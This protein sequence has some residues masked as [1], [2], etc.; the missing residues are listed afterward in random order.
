MQIELSKIKSSPQAIRTT[1]SEEKMDELAQS[2]KQHGLLQ[3]VKVR[4]AGDKYE[5]V[6]GHRRVEACRR[7]GLGVIEAVVKDVG[8][9]TAL[10]QGLIENI[11]RE[12]LEPLDKALGLKVLQDET[13]WSLREMEQ[14]LG[15]S[16]G[17]VRKLL[18]LLEEPKEIQQML[19]QPPAGVSRGHTSGTITAK[20]VEQVRA[21]KLP[22]EQHIA[23]LKKAAEEGLTASQARVEARILKTYGTEE[24]Q[25]AR[26]ERHAQQDAKD[27]EQMW[28]TYQAGEG[29]KNL[30][31][32]IKTTR[33]SFAHSWLI[34]E[35]GAIGPE[36][37]PYLEKRL[38]VLGEYLV[39]L[40]DDLDERRKEAIDE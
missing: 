24:E 19:T 8:P 18:A 22:Q 26:V 23:I 2:I 9:N 35:R 14:H 4:P 25:V 16:F 27:D 10:I 31:R 20:H 39:G 32:T 30:L 37:M 7:L 36:H 6:Y 5:I 12:D 34:V 29:A 15:I 17:Y 11:Q 40:A 1:R 13:G 3:A 38:R 33:E 21:E 28:W